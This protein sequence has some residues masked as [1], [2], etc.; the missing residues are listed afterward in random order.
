[1]LD[2]RDSLMSNTDLLSVFME[3]DAEA[4]VNQII[5]QMMLPTAISAK[6]GK[7]RVL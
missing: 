5:T 6:K 3:L 1:M 7:S 4:E 2:I